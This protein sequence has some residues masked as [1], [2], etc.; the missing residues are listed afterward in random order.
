V[1]R[2]KKFGLDLFNALKIGREDKKAKIMSWRRNFSG[3]EAHAY[4]FIFTY[5]KMGL[6]AIFDCG[7]FA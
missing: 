7:A 2:I 4:V 6:S 1:R 5:E 3:F